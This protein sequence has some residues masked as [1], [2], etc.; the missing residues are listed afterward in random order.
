MCTVTLQ[1]KP[2]NNFVLTS[3]RDES[4]NRETLAPQ[5]YSYKGSNMIYPKD[6]RAGGSWIG[7]SDNKSMVCLLNGGYRKHIP[8]P[9]YRLSRGIVVKELLSSL[10]LYKRLTSFNYIGIEPFTIIAAQWKE[11]L[12]FYELIWDGTKAHLSTLEGTNY[13]WS[14]STLYDKKSQ[15]ARS[16]WFREFLKEK[17]ENS[18]QFLDFH[19]TAGHDN[20]DF[21]L[22]INRGLLKTLSVT[23]ITKDAN[24]VIMRYE[25]LL[26]DSPQVVYNCLKETNSQVTS[27]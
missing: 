13:I 2:N 27:K 15:K 23:Q 20:K 16:M 8:K 19:K 6:I 3:N 25:E 26:K 5:L 4:V 22:Q 12:E 9:P 17:P 14:S 7:M 10:N 1:L 18:N 11:V 24:E 21:G